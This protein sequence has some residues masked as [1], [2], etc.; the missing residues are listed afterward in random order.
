MKRIKAALGKVLLFITSIR[1]YLI[2]GLVLGLFGWTAL[3][4]GSITNP[5]VDQESFEARRL[6]LEANRV[7]FDQDTLNEVLNRSRLGPS[8]EPG[9]TGDT[10]PFD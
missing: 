5:P 3:R 2:A 4:M 8:T 9:S 7:R 1:V 10:N 6:Q